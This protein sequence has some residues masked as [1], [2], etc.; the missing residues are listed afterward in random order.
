MNKLASIQFNEETTLQKVSYNGAEE[1][2]H[3]PVH[4][5][6]FIF[7][8][9]SNTDFKYRIVFK[10][11]YGAPHD[12][13]LLSVVGEELIGDYWRSA[14]YSE[15]IPETDTICQWVSEDFEVIAR[16]LLQE[17]KTN[18]P[19]VAFRIA[20]VY[21]PYAYEKLKSFQEL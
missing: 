6:D 3:E 19:N 20:T 21:G 16:T 11:F 8:L 4:F 10:F 5:K 18:F 17:V 2:V 12:T 15:A 9:H 13:L 1:K 14:T 7:T